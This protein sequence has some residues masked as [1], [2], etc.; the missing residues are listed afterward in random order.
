[1]EGLVMKKILTVCAFLL[2]ANMA[3]ADTWNCRDLYVGVM[4]VTNTS[5]T[6]VFKNARLNG[7]GSYGQ[8]FNGWTED[9][10]KTA[11]SL[12]LAA[13]ASGHRVNVG[14]AKAGGC[15]IQQGG[16]ALSYVQLATNP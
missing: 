10:K 14:T 12:L 9:N 13:K 7:S 16:G 15:G 4:H 1:M 8:S 3:N 5:T 6:V 2:C 11:I